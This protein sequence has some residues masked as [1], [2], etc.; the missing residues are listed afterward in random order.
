[1][2]TVDAVVIGAGHNGLVAANLLADA[3]WEVLVLEA[4]AEAGGSVH[5]TELAP[6]YR[7]DTCSAFYPLGAGSPV[8]RD[9]DLEAYGLVWRH[10]PAVLAHVLP[11]D[12]C[13]VLHR[14]VEDTAAS[15]SSFSR[16]DGAAWRAEAARWRHISGPLLD[17]MLRPFPPVRAGA[18]LLG[19]LGAAE[20]LRLARL[21]VLPVRRYGLER[22]EGEGARLLLAGNALHT[23]LV[24]ARHGDASGVRGAACLWPT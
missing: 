19:R 11:D 20:A 14:D 10:A 4:T 16:G 23:D 5:T 2:R 1:V 12:R 9:L 24:P 18:R 21:S 7:T 8:L 13:A 15:L 17:A 6:G 3:G 22:F